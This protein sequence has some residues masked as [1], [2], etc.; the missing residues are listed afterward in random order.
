M[1]RAQEVALG[2]DLFLA[3][4]S[5]LTVYPAS[6]FPIMAKQN[7]AGLVIINREPT[8]LDGLADLVVHGEAGP[9]LAAVVANLSQRKGDRAS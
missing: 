5:S 9:T 1:R 4:G 7:G 3:V 6:G 2:C 8:E